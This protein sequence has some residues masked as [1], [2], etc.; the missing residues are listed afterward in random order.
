MTAL[1]QCTLL[2][3]WIG[4]NVLWMEHQLYQGLICS[5]EQKGI[6]QCKETI[7]KQIKKLNPAG[8]VRS[9][10]IKNFQNEW[11]GEILWHL[12]KISFSIR[13]T[14]SLPQ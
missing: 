12:Y 9:L 7:L 14:L 10:Q 3:F 1:I 2:I 5:A 6:K 11:K 4:I 8:D 13:Q